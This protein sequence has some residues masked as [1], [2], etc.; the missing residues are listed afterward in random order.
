[1]GDCGICLA[2][3]MRIQNSKFKII[4][5][6]WPFFII[7]IRHTPEAIGRR[8]VST[9]G[10]ILC[11]KSPFTRHKAQIITISSAHFPAKGGL[12][13]CGEKQKK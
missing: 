8:W 6:A 3:E 12:V 7:L 13:R 2:R 4:G 9:A 5:A 1:M 10:K 11:K